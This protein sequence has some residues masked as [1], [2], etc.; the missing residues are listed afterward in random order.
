MS[1]SA[2][3][4][5][6]QRLALVAV[7]GGLGAA[8]RFVVTVALPVAAEEP[9]LATPA[10]VAVNLT[11]ALV[12]GFLRGVLELDQSRGRSVEWLDAFLLV[13]ICG[14]YTSYS[15]FAAGVVEEWH[16]SRALA[17]CTAVA[18][19]VLAPIAA[20]IGMRLSGGYSARPLG[21]NR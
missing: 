6:S 3:L 4:R 19:L 13:G 20:L 9:W 7:G 11:G 18:T 21:N 8:L 16:V 15:A 10:L 5:V 14:G 17:I 1:T 12:A 2:K